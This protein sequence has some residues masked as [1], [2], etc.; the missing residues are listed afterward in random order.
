MPVIGDIDHLGIH[1]LYPRQRG[2]ESHLTKETFTE[3]GP[4]IRSNKRRN[5]FTVMNNSISDIS[6]EKI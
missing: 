1:M 3:E 6:T 2:E 5:N 4:E